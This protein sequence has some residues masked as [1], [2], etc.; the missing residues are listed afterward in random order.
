MAEMKA[1]FESNKNPDSA[2]LNQLAIYTNLQPRVLR[3]S[4]LCSR[5]FVDKQLD[6]ELILMYKS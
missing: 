4:D 3:V 2:Q 5:K 6:Y 1:Y